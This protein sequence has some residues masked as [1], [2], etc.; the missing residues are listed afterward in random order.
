M[1][2]KKDVLFFFGIDVVLVVFDLFN[3]GC[4]KRRIYNNDIIIR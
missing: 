3:F 2:L 1:L 4:Y